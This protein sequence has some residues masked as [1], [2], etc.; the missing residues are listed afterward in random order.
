MSVEWAV[1][2]PH[3]AVR[4][5]VAR[6][7]GYT[8]ESVTLEVH[9][10]LPS[11]YVTMIISLAEP[12]RL[13]E[14][15]GFGALRTQGMVGGMHVGPALIGQ[16]RFQ[17]G[18]HLELNPLGVR[19][20]LGV[21]AASLAG[22]V[23]GLEQFSLGSL[24]DRLRSAPDWASR[25]SIL[26]TV[27]TASAA[28]VDVSREVGWAWQSMVG[29]GGRTRVTSLADEIGWSRRHFGERFRAEVGLSPK[30]AAR[31]LRFE[32]AAGKLRGGQLDLASLAVE[33]GYYDQ[34][35]LSN[36]WR[37]LAG[38]SPRT[39]ILEELPFLQDSDVFALDT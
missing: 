22:Q 37:A 31:V 7:V 35:H 14:G 30:Q 25:F 26:D 5:L 34:A 16:D 12:I 21:S 4:H 19:A 15:A 2:V 39:W 29:A 28:E 24:P 18:I 33:C 13:L 8:Q 36:E 17:S 20:L 38:C 32:R 3:P 27:L 23:V 10:G 9:R 11:R 6:Y 1:G